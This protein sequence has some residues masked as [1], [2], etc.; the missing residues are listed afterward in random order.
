MIV[1]SL[2]SVNLGV[3]VMLLEYWTLYSDRMDV[4]LFGSIF[5][6]TQMDIGKTTKEK[7]DINSCY[8]ILN[9][10]SS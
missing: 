2:V 3:G 6:K 10:F 1:A 7:K 4:T 9:I 8:L 5:R